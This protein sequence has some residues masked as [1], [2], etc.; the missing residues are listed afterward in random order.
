[1]R[2][3]LGVVFTFC[4]VIAWSCLATDAVG[5]ANVYPGGMRFGAA[6][7]GVAASPARARKASTQ[8][9]ADADP[10]ASG[11]SF[12]FDDALHWNNWSWSAN[13]NP[14]ATSPV[15]AGATS[16]AIT[17]TA[18]YAGA[19]FNHAGFDATPFTHLSFMIHPKDASRSALRVYLLDQT[20]AKLKFVD[21]SAYATPSTDGW[22]SVSIPLSALSGASK[23]LTG[24]VLHEFSGNAQPTFYVDNLAFVGNPPPT[25]AKPTAQ[26]GSFIYDE[27]L[28]WENSSWSATLDPNVTAPVFAGATS[29][30]ITFTAEYAG[31]HFSTAGFDATPFTHL[32]FMI[33]PNGA[34]LPALRVYLVD[35]T[36]AN[37][38]FADPSGY[39]TPSTQGW[40]SVSIPLSAL[41]GE[42]K[43][44]TGVVLYE[45]AG[46]AQ[47][48]FYVDNLAF[49]SNSLPPKRESAL[50]PQSSSFIYDE[51]LHWNNW[52]WGAT[53]NPN[54]NAPVFAGA[55]SL[56]VTFTA[57]YAGA[58]FNHAG[59]D[60]T[61]FMHL[62]FM[63]HPEGV[64][65]RAMRVYLLDATGAKLKFVDP[66][67]Y[68]T[69]S[70]EGWYSVKIPLSALSGE[71]KMLTGVVLH[72]F[73]GSAQPTFYVDDLAFAGPSRTPAGPVLKIR[74]GR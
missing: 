59:F 15:F 2:K 36:G 7:P 54:V 64:S 26:R 29:L 55:K 21:P 46:A 19:Y 20:G 6:D 37:L 45:F 14:S 65:L 73:S 32:S 24:V 28:H 50:P 58:Y 63:I 48:T 49:V 10:A 71:S 68:A 5:A 31:A 8:D 11:G 16:L 4:V 13:L 39:A 57:G 38:T 61:P 70:T 69:S 1:M 12:I 43:M 53:L 41:S 33:H 56:G 27:T 40:Y 44:L 52:S 22:F 60:T 67:A 23:V 62:S 51:T 25:I 42:S 74:L 35:S 34:S 66:S 30:G 17:F 3:N 18:G 47:P 9:A 72:E